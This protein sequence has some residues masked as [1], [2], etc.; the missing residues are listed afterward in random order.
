MQLVL[1]LAAAKEF[2]F[3]ERINVGDQRKEKS[4]RE[5]RKLHDT[6]V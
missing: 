5:I 2:P 3:N 1:F 4:H 6:V